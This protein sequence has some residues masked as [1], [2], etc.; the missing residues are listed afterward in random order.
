MVESQTP[1][2]L[3]VVQGPQPELG[4]YIVL[5]HTLRH[6]YHTWEWRAYARGVHTGAP[7]LDT[8]V[9]PNLGLLISYDTL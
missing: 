4:V 5:D 8:N 9:Q 7:Q 1:L 2:S 6:P 3:Q